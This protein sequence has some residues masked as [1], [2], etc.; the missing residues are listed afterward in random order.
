M[1][2]ICRGWLV[3]VCAFCLM[4]AGIAGAQDA[5]VDTAVAVL[6]DTVAA[7]AVDTGSTVIVRV[8]HSNDL[9]GELFRGSGSDSLGGMVP[10]VH[11][12]RRIQERGPAVV[13]DAGDAIG[14]ATLSAWDKGKTMVDLM[15]VAGYTA[16]A[17]GNHE[18]DYGLETFNKRQEQAGFPFLAANIVAQGGAELA[19]IGHILVKAGGARIG[20]FGVVTPDI[21]EQTNPRNVA[22]LTFGD[23]LKAARASIEALNGQGADYVIGVVHMPEEAVLALA[24]RLSGV[25]LIV[26]GVW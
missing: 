13:L 1:I 10:R 8:V 24:R 14:P 21:T 25:D 16:L 22:G 5:E 4:D 9:Y 26:A 20:I 2:S 12:I 7:A 15:R 19:T 6:E 11:L 23:P 18:F 3:L 17:P